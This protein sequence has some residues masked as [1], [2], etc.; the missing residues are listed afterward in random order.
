[1][2]NNLS[3]LLGGSYQFVYIYIYHFSGYFLIKQ[4]LF[5][6]KDPGENAACCDSRYRSNIQEAGGL[7]C[8]DVGDFG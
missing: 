3:V 2:K 6:A 1:M 8:C 7:F 5:T 4:G